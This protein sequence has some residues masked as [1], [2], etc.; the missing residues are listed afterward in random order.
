MPYEGGEYD[1]GRFT[2]EAR[3]WDHEHCKICGENIPAM[4]LC[5][6]TQNGPN[7]LLC[8]GCYERP[9]TSKQHRR[10]WWKFW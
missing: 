2:I 5:W 4:T 6:V 7:I 9:V 3:V 10:P 8:G 1:S